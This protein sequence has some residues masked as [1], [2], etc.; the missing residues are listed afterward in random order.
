MEEIPILGQEAQKV[1]WKGLLS[2]AKDALS[3]I[4]IIIV[5]AIAYG[6][7]SNTLSNNTNDIV[8]VRSEIHQLSDAVNKLSERMA[9]LSGQLD[10]KDKK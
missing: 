4:T 7:S 3:V 8:A 5:S 10:S 9:Y 6:R 1:N 2:A